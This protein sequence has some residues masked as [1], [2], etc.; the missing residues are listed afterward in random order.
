MDQSDTVNVK[1][2]LIAF[3]RYKDSVT[4]NPFIRPLES[5]ASDLHQG[6]SNTSDTFGTTL[7][8]PQPNLLKCT[9]A[10]RHQS[11]AS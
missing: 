5:Q 9:T 11:R 8:P 7:K 6:I 3:K 2:V 4:S 10:Q 1:R